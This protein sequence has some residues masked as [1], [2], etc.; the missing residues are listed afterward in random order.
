MFKVGQ[1][2]WFFNNRQWGEVDKILKEEESPDVFRVHVRFGDSPFLPRFTIDGKYQLHQERTLFFEE[3]P[4]PPAALDPKL[5]RAEADGTYY[6]ISSEMAITITID[7]YFERDDFRHKYGNYFKTPEDAQ[8][9]LDK[10]L[11]VLKEY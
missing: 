3:I 8:I 1:K 5:W 9:A 6:Y 7:E 4:I 10:M 11:K 2:V